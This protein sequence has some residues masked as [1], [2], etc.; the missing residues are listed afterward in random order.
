MGVAHALGESFMNGAGSRSLW[1]TLGKIF[2]VFAE[3]VAGVHKSFKRRRSAHRLRL[4]ET[5]SLGEK[6]FLAVV[7][8]QQQ[9]FL[10]GGTG[11]SIALLARLDSAGAMPDSQTGNQE[12]GV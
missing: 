8:F 6:R 7:Q 5:L 1:A 12:N 2:A 10:V 9:E 11:N 4:S 3:H